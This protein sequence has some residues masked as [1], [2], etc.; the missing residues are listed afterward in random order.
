MV[1][2]TYTTNSATISL[3]EDIYYWR[4][5]A[6]DLAGNQGPFASHESFGVDTT[7]PVI[8]ST[9]EWTDTTYIGPFE[10]RT[11]VTDNLAGLDSVLL[12][13][14]R[15]E[16]PDWVIETM[17]QSGDWFTDTIPAVTNSN[18]TVRYYIRAIDYATNESTDPTGAP[19]SYYS[20]IA[21]LLGI[22]ESSETPSKFNFKVN[23]LVKGKAI[24]RFAVPKRSRITLKI[25][26]ATGRI[27]SEP[28]SGNYHAGIYQVSF[29]PSRGGIY[30][31]RLESS[32]TNRTGKLVIF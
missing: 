2:D 22:V 19:A 29:K 18:D 6:Y 25:Y 12:Y 14:K 9:T 26:D 21:N 20:F 3:N 23:S 31:Y 28:L 5:M 16:D 32:Y 10:I 11:K 1:V 13:Y 8:E 4:V 17:H 15:D 7:A 30:F 27:I 24:F